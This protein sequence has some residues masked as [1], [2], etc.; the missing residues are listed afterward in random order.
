MPVRRLCLTL[1][2]LALLQSC[3]APSRLETAPQRACRDL[4]AAVDRAVAASAVRDAQAA[5]IAGFPYLRVDR[6]L[7]SYRGETQVKPVFAAWI[8]GLR[9]LDREARRVELANLPPT[10]RRA[11][12]TEASAQ[13]E[14]E[15]ALD[16]CGDELAGIDLAA[17][18]GREQLRRAAVVPDEYRTAW[19]ILG[20]YPV[21]GWVVSR[22]VE[23]LHRATLETFARP[24]DELP[25]RGEL[26]RY[27]P[28]AAPGVTV[29]EAAA[30]VRAAPRDALGVPV[31]TDE[32]REQLYA[33]HAPVFA[34]DTVSTD[35]RIGAP[36][37]Q[38]D[39]LP[40]VNIADP[41][42]YRRLSHVR[43][44]GEMLLQLSYTVWFPARPRAGRLD[45][46]GGRFDGITLR[47]TLG[48]D[49]LPLLYD[50]MHNCACY[51]QFYPTE[52]L[53]LRTEA[54]GGWEPPLV[55]Q[56][57]PI[58]QAGER[59]AI[60]AERGT[61]YVQR[62][63]AE[64]AELPGV[65]LRPDDYNALRSLPQPGGRRSLFGPDGVVPGSERAE[66]YVLWPMG[67]PKPGAQRQ[68]GHHPIAFVGR[69]H[70]DDPYLLER[71]FE[72]NE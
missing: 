26:T 27:R 32:A 21:T 24:F 18:G 51:H 61:H 55:A 23:R 34:I 38:G 57:V 28:P 17:A 48:S 13:P 11:L 47:V 45:L 8:A 64:S 3:A 31:L 39:A 6:F 1:L 66:R 4:Y 71:Y 19:R 30:L 9:A 16:R 62:I 29:A 12:E 59:L 72:P 36:R 35:D 58:L 37:W 42:V 43:W 40:D 15:T 69:R 70:F 49:G 52:R 22:Q 46:L 60:R 2:V 68:W 10:A 56:H 5:A 50:S 53:R 25:V 65:E 41:A 20:L 67:V 7:A 14:L 33:A 54:E 44:R 63:Y